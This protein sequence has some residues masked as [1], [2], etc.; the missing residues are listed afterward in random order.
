[1]VIVAISLIVRGLE[2]PF[3]EAYVPKLQQIGTITRTNK[4]SI[5]MTFEELI[6]E[7]QRIIPKDRSY[8]VYQHTNQGV[9][10]LYQ[11]NHHT[12]QWW[13]VQLDENNKTVRSKTPER[14]LEL[15]QQYLI[16]QVFQ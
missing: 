10:P 5:S 11:G 8:K 9:G 3:Y 15:V 2:S 12:L 6:I 1:M 16:V 13:S 7:L 4:E 14:L